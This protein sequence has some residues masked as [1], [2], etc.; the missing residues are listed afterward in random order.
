MNVAGFGG[1]V[2]FL[3][4]A[5]E[6]GLSAVE[7]ALLHQAD[8]AVG[9]SVQLVFDGLAAGLVADRQTLDAVLDELAILGFV[10]GAGGGPLAVVL[11][12]QRLEVFRADWR[13]VG[14]SFR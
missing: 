12:V 8:L 1:L 2:E 9:G 6:V 7:F 5:V 4:S 11:S 3:D 14:A 10:I 13:R